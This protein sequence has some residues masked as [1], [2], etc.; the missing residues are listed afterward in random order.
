MYNSDT[1]SVQP[2]IDTTYY[3][4]PNGPVPTQI[5]VQLTWNGTAQPF[6]TFQTTGHSPGDAYL[7]ATQVA[8]PVTT[9]GAY[10]WKV[11][12]QATLPLPGNPSSTARSAVRPTSWSTAPAIRTARD[13]ALA[14]RPGCTRT[15][16]VG[17]SGPTATAAAATSSPAAVTTFFSPPND[18]GTLV[19]NADGS[20]TYTN[21][22]Q[23]KWN[24]N[25]QGFLT[26]VV[27]PDGPTEM[28]A[29]NSRAP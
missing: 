20:F 26:S 10:P 9:T 8:S 7:L 12:I 27:E 29:Y 23:E 3:S 25:S 2:I 16:W 11:E 18:Q 13:G 22:Q 6:V 14:E 24:F 4:D 21:P 1:V 17:S 5:Q 19:K 28:F 15:A